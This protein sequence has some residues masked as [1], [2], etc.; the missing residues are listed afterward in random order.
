M[1]ILLSGEHYV[2]NDASRIVRPTT[3][4][5]KKKVGH[6]RP[7]PYESESR[8]TALQSPYVCMYVGASRHTARHRRRK[9]VVVAFPS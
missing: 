7:G 2:M 3:S 8:S 5:L 1:W 9:K 6:P 4:K